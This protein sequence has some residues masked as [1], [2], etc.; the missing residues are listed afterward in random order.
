MDLG[1]YNNRINL[2]ADFY[3][4]QTHD[5]LLDAPVPSSSGYTT[6]TRNIGSMENK[7]LEVSL[8]TVNI[9]HKNLTWTTNFN[10]STLKNRVTALGAKNEDII[11]GFKDLLLL[12]VGQSVGSFYGYIRDGIWS[13]KQAKEAAAYGQLPGDLRIRDLNNDGVINGDDR[14]IIGKGI[15]DFFGTFS[16]TVRYKNFDL[17]LELQYMSGN[18]VFDNSRNSGEA[19]QGIANSY[20]SVLN[21]WTPDNQD[22]V[23]EQVRPTGA[24]YA[25]Y[26]DTR[27]LQDG[28]FIR[29]KNLLLGYTLP[30]SLQQRWGLNNL[31]V[32]ASFQN[33]FIITN[34]E[35]Y[36]PEVSNYD[37]DVFS[38]G[39]NY[40]SYP[41]PRT[42]MLGLN[43]SF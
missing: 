35:G 19:R 23:L 42:L 34:Y 10:I 1:L 11:Y 7:G 6:V 43:V 29:G 18:D 30:A 33:F 25:Y 20:A 12:R 13:T 38:Q 41:K 5:L 28:S 2:V 9:D 22:A 21:A 37:N 39:V 15:P 40:A 16:N 3:S 32:Y 36:D 14:T 31:R 24:G 27:K 26:M 8:N 17:T 4:K